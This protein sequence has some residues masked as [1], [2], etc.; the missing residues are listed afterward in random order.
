MTDHDLWPRYRDPDQPKV[1]KIVFNPGDAQS[2]VAIA[3]SMGCGVSHSEA[4]RLSA[5]AEAE[6]ADL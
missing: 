3:V 5:D 1:V 4:S 6:Y 2:S